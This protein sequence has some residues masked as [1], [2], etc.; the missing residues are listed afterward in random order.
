M[1]ASK[2]SG[3]PSKITRKLEKSSSESLQYHILKKSSRRRMTMTNSHLTFP[4]PAQ[5]RSLQGSSMSLRMTA[6]MMAQIRKSTGSPIQNQSTQ[7]LLHAWVGARLNCRQ[8]ALALK[9]Q[10]SIPVLSIPLNYG[11]QDSSENLD[12]ENSAPT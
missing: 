5:A 12:F 7:C 2:W 10:K 8:K 6:A 4:W 1:D 11:F 3:Y 9:K